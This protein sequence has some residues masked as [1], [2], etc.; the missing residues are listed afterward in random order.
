[1][2]NIGKCVI[3]PFFAIALGKSAIKKAQTGGF[4]IKLSDGGMFLVGGKDLVENYDGMSK[5]EAKKNT[6]A[7]NIWRTTIHRTI[8][9]NYR[10][11]LIR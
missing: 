9:K 5:E 7:Y 11:S 3:A 8:W 6:M 4:M 10:L 2:Y 1:M